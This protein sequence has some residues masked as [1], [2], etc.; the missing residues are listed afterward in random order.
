MLKKEQVRPTI[1]DGGPNTRDSLPEDQKFKVKKS[2]VVQVSQNGM[3][4]YNCVQDDLVMTSGSRQLLGCKGLEV[5]FGQSLSAWAQ[6]SSLQTA[7]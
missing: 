3:S 4:V 5:S 6:T 2:K 1:E 7:L